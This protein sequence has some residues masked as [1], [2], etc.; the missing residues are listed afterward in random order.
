M[1]SK[2]VAGVILAAGGS[3]RFGEIKQLLPWKNKNIINTVVETA[4]LA[5]LDPILVV[6]GANAG[7]IQASLDNETIQ[8][9]TNPDWDKGQSTS[10]KAGVTAIRHTVDGVLFLLCDQPHLTVNLVNAVVE[11]GL[12]SGKVVTPIIDDRRANPVYFPAS[13]FPLFDTLEGDAGGRQII[14]ACPHTTLPW[15]DDWMA[16]D[17]DT[18]EDYRALRDHFGL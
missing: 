11:E 6:L 15:L 13:C 1:I 14:P 9:V 12:R 8:V 3:S 4:A 18:P 16:R 2:K 5:D 10:L 17:I 7:L